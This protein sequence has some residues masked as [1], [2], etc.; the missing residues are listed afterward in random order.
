[1]K[2]IR[3][4]VICHKPSYVPGLPFLVPIQAG[5]AIA[6]KHIPGMQGD[7]QGDSISEKNPLYCELTPQYWAWKNEDADYYGF[8]HYRRYLTFRP[9][10]RIA[11]N[12]TR[13]S[14]DGSRR[15]SPYQCPFR[16]IGDI[17][18][19]D[20]ERYGY[21]E[22]RIRAVM[23]R[24]D[25]V[26]VL[27]ERIDTS[28]YHQ[29][30]QYHDRDVLNRVLRILTRKYPDYVQDALGYLSSHDIYYMNMYVMKKEVFREYM[31]WLFDLLDT[32][33]AEDKASGRGEAG[34][35]RIMGFLA[36]RLFGIFYA[37]KR[38]TGLRCAEVPYLR[39]YQT[40][41]DGKGKDAGSVRTFRLGN[42]S[43]SVRAD[44]RLLNRLVPAGSRRR[45]LLRKFL[46][47]T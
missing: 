45:L 28:V 2:K 12:G 6:E 23:K 8:F 29:F 10:Y 39:F 30:S 14:P 7:D 19:T 11:E 36:E 21:T 25:L 42:G 33:A 24:Y 9:V 26:T 32:F 37:H 47:R 22:K 15:E 43:L 31:A 16:E 38:R 1:M 44:M 35:P 34:E 13:L 5:A 41:P 17:R 20:W 18:G 4:Y 3:I 40:A 46:I 27:R